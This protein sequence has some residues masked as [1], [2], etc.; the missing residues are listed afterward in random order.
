MAVVSVEPIGPGCSGKWNS[1][2]QR[3]YTLVYRVTCDN[4]YDG[5]VTIRNATKEGADGK[6]G[7]WLPAI[8][9]SYFVSATEKDLG[10]FLNEVE[11]TWEDQTAAG[12]VTEGL[13]NPGCVWVVKCSYSPYD[14]GAFGPDPCQ[15]PIRMSFGSEKYQKVILVDYNGNPILNSAGCPY[16]DPAQV[17]NSRSIITVKT[18]IPLVSYEGANGVVAAFDPTMP[19]AYRDKINN[20]TWNG[21]PQYQVKMNS[22]TT[23]D[24]Q[25][26]S[27]NQRYYY[28]VTFEI[29]INRDTWQ[30]NI[31]DQGKQVLDGSG[32]PTPL[33]T[34][35]GQLID[36]PV[37]L[38]GSGH[39]LASGGTP[40][41]QNYQGY[42]PV[43]FTPLGLNFA[44]AIGRT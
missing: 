19:E 18:N 2:W 7:P 32:E 40:V 34:A 29:D 35:E 15:W 28:E 27:N 25:Y 42:V 5:P 16:E 23:G 4:S 13:T 26:D 20:D 30:I 1:T 10:S 12:S 9:T 36:E 8:G 22:I 14:A 44:N 17:D 38:D 41:F 3:Y 11:Y 31:L 33:L 24:E 37:L 39:E 43:D 6:I 21:F